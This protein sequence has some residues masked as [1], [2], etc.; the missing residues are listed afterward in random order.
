MIPT[1]I[2]PEA[3]KLETKIP[4]HAASLW[5]ILIF[6]LAAITGLSMFKDW[7][8]TGVEPNVWFYV[9]VPLIDTMGS[10]FVM[11]LFARLFRQTPKFSEFLAITIGVAIVM[12]MVE[13]ITKLVYYKV[14]EY[15]GWM[16]FVFVF[17]LWFILTASVLVKYTQIKWRFSL[18]LTVLGFIGSLVIGVTYTELTGL[19]TPGS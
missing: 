6:G 7:W 9:F 8:L 16:Y 4:I 2:Q 18:L 3:Q 12:Q 11:F 5:V 19:E 13:I 17:S 14:W 10:A 1:D 15:P